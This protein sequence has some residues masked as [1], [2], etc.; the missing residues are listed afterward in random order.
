MY[1]IVHEDCKS[2]AHALDRLGYQAIIRPSPVK[3][4]EIKGDFLRNHIEHENCCGSAEFIKLHAYNL[5]EHPI[6]VHWDMDVALFQPM[7][8]LFDSMLYSANSVE[9]ML[10][11][12]R[13]ELQHPERPLP[14]RIDAFITRDITSSKP[15]EKHQ[16]VQGGF[17]VARPSE[18]NFDRYLAFIRDGNYTKGRGDGSGWHGLGYGGFQGA[19]AYQGAVAFFYDQISPNTAV[20]LDICVWNQVVADVIW[21]GPAQM[22]YYGQCR[23]YPRPGDDFEDNTPEKKRCNDCRV[24]PVE[25]VKSA[26]YTACKKPWECQIPR[27]RV[28]RDKR[29][30]HR[31]QELT[32]VTTCGLLFKKWFD[33]R[34]DF[35]DLVQ[36]AVGIEPA[37]RDGGYHPEYF[38]GSCD[39]AGEYHPM[40]PPPADFDITRMYGM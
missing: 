32:N 35:E 21:R 7:D 19:M 20:E 11:R 15:W 36:G 8:D 37:D 25:K 2:H 27:P 38:G 31:L 39:R 4:E 24:L 9:G 40:N 17:L 29:E 23:E 3:K 6:A 30:V 1:A 34:H 33:L 5:M 10:A 22:E 18:S 14:N 13:L 26:H 28:P 12:S 16:G